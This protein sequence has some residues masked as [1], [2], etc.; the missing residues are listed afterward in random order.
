MSAS[1]AEGPNAPLRPKKPKK[2]RAKGSTPPLDDGDQGPETEAP[3]AKRP[4]P[5]IALDPSGHL[6]GTMVGLDAAFRAFP[7]FIPR[8]SPLWPQLMADS[9]AAFL[10]NSFWL[11]AEQ[12]P[13]CTL[14]RAARAIFAFHTKDAV[15]DAARSGAEWW[16]QFR[17]KASDDGEAIGFHWDKDERWRD[18]YDQYIHPQIAT[19]TYL[20]DHG[21]PTLVLGARPLPRTVG[22][23]E[24]QKG[25]LAHPRRGKHIAFDGRYLH[26][27]A[28]QLMVEKPPKG[29]SRATFL[30]NVWLHHRPEGCDPFPAD[31]LP[32]LSNMEVD[33]TLE[34]KRAEP[35][36]VHTTGAT[37]VRGF[38][39]GTEQEGF[40]L[41]YPVARCADK[42]ADN[43]RISFGP[44][45]RACILRDQSDRRDDRRAR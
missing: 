22:A 44:G 30:V 33:F 29:Y 36:A 41:E 25:F 35:T 14:E 5:S 6:A 32:G 28:P 23:R 21:G 39:F 38:A 19:V 34:G 24:V 11:A 27:V 10:G 18:Q 15:Y 9:E 20:T 40:I 2:K 17:S 43:L 3:P 12:V 45:G 1:G 8:D 7:G 31:K 37:P 42:S 13:R 16:V 26:G 4:R